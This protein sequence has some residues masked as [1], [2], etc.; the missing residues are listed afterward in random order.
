MFFIE[1]HAAANKYSVFRWSPNVFEAN[2]QLFIY[3]QCNETEFGCKDGSCLPDASRCNEVFD[4]N[5]K[6]DEKN[7]DM[8]VVDKVSII[9]TCEGSFSIHTECDRD[10]DQLNLVKLGLGGSV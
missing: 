8:V 5:G 2:V 6:F 7:C 4:C 3:F 10:L 1:Q 9:S